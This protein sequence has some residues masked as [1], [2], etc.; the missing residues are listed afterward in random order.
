MAGFLAALDALLARYRLVAERRYVQ[1]GDTG[2]SAH[3]LIAG[4]GAPLVLVIGG[5]VPAA[6]WVPLMAQLRGHRM[7]AIELPGFGLTDSAIYTADTL[8]RTAVDHLAGILDA[9]RLGPA[10]FVTQSMGSQWTSWLAA[11]QPGRVQRQVMIACP[12][13]FLD[14]SAIAPF[15]LASVPGLGPLLMTLQRPSTKNAARTMR[16]VGEDPD[17]IAELRDVLVAT[18]RLPTYTT[19]LLALMRS[20]MSWTRP[21]PQIVTTASQLQ[22]VQHPVRLIWGERDPFGSVGA[23]QRIADLIPDADLHVVPGGHTP[24]FHHAERIG[25]LTHEFL[26]DGHEHPASFRQH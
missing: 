16:A 3:V 17:G 24:W 15:R 8:R 19:S 4:D 7:Y 14:T 1:V 21:R 11:E 10:P 9:L 5:A 18:Q 22:H 6:F 13:F 2:R 23:G 25:R 12:A 26:E 20:V